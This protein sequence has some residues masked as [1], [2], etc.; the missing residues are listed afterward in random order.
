MFSLL[1]T[2]SFY[3]DDTHGYHMNISDRAAIKHWC[4]KFKTRPS[5]YCLYMFWLHE[6]M[7]H[8]HIVEIVSFFSF[9]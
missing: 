3:Q 5:N 8:I 1:K 2:D 4:N 9:F 7:L 6:V